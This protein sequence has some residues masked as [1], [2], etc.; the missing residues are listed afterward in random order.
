MPPINTAWHARHPMPPHATEAQRLRWHLAHQRHCACRPIPESLAKLAA[1]S[2]TPSSPPSRARPAWMT[3]RPWSVASL[4]TLRGSGLYAR[5][6][7]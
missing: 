6:Q 5:R 3:R 2:A 7:L 4:D 1:E